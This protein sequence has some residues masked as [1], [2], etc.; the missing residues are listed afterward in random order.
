MNKAK[1]NKSQTG[2]KQQE[3]RRI[4]QKKWGRKRQET[5]RKKIDENIPTTALTTASTTLQQHSNNGPNDNFVKA[6]A[7][8]TEKKIY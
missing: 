4:K 2:A 1:E 8:I 5:K 7:M 6:P 3:T